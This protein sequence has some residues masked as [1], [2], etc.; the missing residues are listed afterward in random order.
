[1][2]S[3][4]VELNISFKLL[5]S[6]FNPRAQ[7]M[8]LLRERRSSQCPAMHTTSNYAHAIET[9]VC[10]NRENGSSALQNLV[11][12]IDLE[13]YQKILIHLPAE[14]NRDQEVL[15]TGPKLHRK[16]GSGC[17]F[18]KP[19]F[20]GHKAMFFSFPL[21]CLSLCLLYYLEIS[22]LHLTSF[23]KNKTNQWFDNMQ[24]YQNRNEIYWHV[25]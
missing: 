4:L 13:N 14:K 15:I 5:L 6:L 21:C 25:L 20:S 24:I 17:N 22:I 23:Q 8:C 7:V 19:R 2:V 9:Q 16:S 18:V 1:M 12:R 11:D 3:N 10:K